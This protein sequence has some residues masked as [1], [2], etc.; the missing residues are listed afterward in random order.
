M[1]PK[2]I[3]KKT[4]SS[5]NEPPLAKLPS[6]K[7]PPPTNGQSKQE[8]AREIAIYHANIIQAQKDVENDILE[9]LE[10]LIEFPTAPDASSAHPAPADV[11]AFTKYITPFQPS[12]YDSL[13]EERRIANKCGYVFC[14]NP[15]KKTSGAGKF[16]I[17]GKKKGAEFKVVEREK[18]DC[19]CSADCARRAL[20]VKVQLDEEPA[21]TRR[22]GSAPE[23]QILVGAD[24]EEEEDVA[25]IGEQRLEDNMKM[26]ALER[27]DLEKPA[28]SVGMVN[29]VVEKDR[30]AAPEPP[31]N[32]DF[33]NTI[34]GYE[35]KGITL[36]IRTKK[37]AKRE[38]GDRDWEL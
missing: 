11:E 29:E 14:S 23:I 12:D 33:R 2:S 6:M 18:T 10:E 15:P 5:M 27:G 34:E 36:A 28:R 21:W 19:W 26:L 30:V 7:E 31:N 22:G 32:A 35:P 8:R 1:A 17:L 16:K 20:Y 25:K 9:A 13:L 37:P 24:E 38:L 4:L 3:L